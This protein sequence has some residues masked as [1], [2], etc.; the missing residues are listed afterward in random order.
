MTILFIFF[1]S[2][3]KLNL[4]KLALADRETQPMPVLQFSI[5]LGI[6]TLVNIL[7][8]NRTWPVRVPWLDPPGRSRWQRTPWYG[9]SAQRARCGRLLVWLPAPP[10]SASDCFTFSNCPFI[11]ALSIRLWCSL[12]KGVGVSHAFQHRKEMFWNDVH[13][14][15]KHK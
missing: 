15:S 14:T 7:G 2:F 6:I 8:I 9:W 3:L 11:L 4:P 1:I 13:N 10:S 12:R 5:V